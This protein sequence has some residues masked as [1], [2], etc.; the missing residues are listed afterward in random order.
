MTHFRPASPP[1]LSH[2]TGLVMILVMNLGR[3]GGRRAAQRGGRQKQGFF[4][5]SA[6]A[7][8]SESLIAFSGEVDFR[9]KSAFSKSGNR[10][11]V[12]TRSTS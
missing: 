3:M 11:C 1:V 2:V 5:L 8:V 7:I 12:R 10:F 4:E 6:A 9:F